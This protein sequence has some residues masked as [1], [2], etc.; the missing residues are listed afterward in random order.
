MGQ[1]DGGT[2]ALRQLGWGDGSSP[3]G[4]I[5]LPFCCCSGGQ[6]WERWEWVP[7]RPS[8]P[9]H[10]TKG[11]LFSSA[12]ARSSST[13]PSPS[14]PMTSAQ[15][16]PPRC[17]QLPAQTLSCHSKRP[18]DRQSRPAWRAQLGTSQGSHSSAHSRT[19]HGGDQAP[20]HNIPAPSVPGAAVAP[21]SDPGLTCRAALPPG[22]A[23][24]PA[25]WRSPSAP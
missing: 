23:S 4:T 13:P 5:S 6:R 10:S 3:W 21:R 24:G 12:G 25:R 11:H 20:L 16:L 15:P 19:W 8:T 7:A 17:R 1:R 18:T 9:G 14:L 22:T 2:S